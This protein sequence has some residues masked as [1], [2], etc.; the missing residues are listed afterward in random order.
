[1]ISMI[2]APTTT[3]G[4]VHVSF[5]S[6]PWARIIYTK[7]AFTSK[8]SFHYVIDLNSIQFGGNIPGTQLV[9]SYRKTTCC[10]LSMLFFPIEITHESAVTTMQLPATS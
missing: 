4:P 6:K 2:V 10:V 3:A 1:M 9:G 5:T 8:I 7:D